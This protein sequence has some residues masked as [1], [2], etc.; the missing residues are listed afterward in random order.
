LIVE[1]AVVRGVLAATAADGVAD[2]AADAAE[3]GTR[4]KATVVV[5]A[6]PV[7]HNRVESFMTCHSFIWVPASWAGGHH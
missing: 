5:R 3:A 2:G 7:A 1:D 4:P 6:A